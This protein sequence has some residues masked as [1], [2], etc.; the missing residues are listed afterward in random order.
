M[1]EAVECYVEAEAFDRVEAL[2]RGSKCIEPADAARHPA[3]DDQRTLH[4]GVE[5]A[6]FVDE[7]RLS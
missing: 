6:N 4:L 5:P 2:R 3:S 1:M 7:S